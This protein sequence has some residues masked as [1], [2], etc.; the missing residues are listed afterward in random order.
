MK[1]INKRNIIWNIIGATTN[2]F[3]SLLFTII[4][5]RIN[6]VSDAGIFA[7]AFAL[8]CWFYVIGVYSGRVFQVT[9]RT[10]KNSDTDYIY[11]RIF[12]CIIMMI[13]AIGFCFVK[14]YDT[15]KSCI[16]IFLCLFKT[17]EAFS[18]CIYAIIQKNGQLYK[19][20]DF[21]VYKSNNRDCYIFCS[22][23]YNKKFIN[24]MHEYS[25]SKCFNIVSV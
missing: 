3:N 8:A 14:Q 6:G 15:Y 10:G 19:V 2:A 5:T 18:E 20:R 9:D 23:L 21:I 4:A 24:L 22:G 16:I 17:I 7:F 11:N 25:C 13:S 12:T 1:N